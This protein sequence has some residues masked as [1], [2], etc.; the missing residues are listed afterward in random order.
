MTRKRSVPSQTD[1]S[2]LR[3][4][5]PLVQASNEHVTCCVWSSGNYDDRM[6]DERP[7]YCL[8]QVILNYAQDM[9]KTSGLVT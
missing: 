7:I 4:W 3:I 1:M 2:P 9:G 6:R 5:I 8:W